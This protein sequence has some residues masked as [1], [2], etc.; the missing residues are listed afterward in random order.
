MNTAE[1][2]AVRALAY[3]IVGS[4]VDGTDLVAVRAHVRA[5]AER[6]RRGE[7]ATLIEA[8]IEPG[9]SPLAVSGARLAAAQVLDARAA[10]ELQAAVQS[11]VT[12][13]IA[14][15]RGVGGPPLAGIID[16]VTAEPSAALREELDD[17]TR[18]R[19]KG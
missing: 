1:T 2:V 4:R 17:L 6:A 12:A 16:G 7:G 3:G 11:E 18:A 8:V 9:H 13:A 5:A 10:S 15:E 19:R 14:A